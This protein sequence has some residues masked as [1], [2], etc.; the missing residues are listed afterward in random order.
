MIVNR[1]K[2]RRLLDALYTPLDYFSGGIDSKD[3]SIG[4]VGIMAVREQQVKVATA[5]RAFFVARR[6]IGFGS[7]VRM[8]VDHVAVVRV[9]VV[10]DAHDIGLADNREIVRLLSGVGG[11]IVFDDRPILATERATGLVGIACDDMGLHLVVDRCGD[12]HNKTCFSYHNTFASN[13]P[14]SS[15]R[16]RVHRSSLRYFQPPSARMATILP[17]SMLSAIRRAACRD[18][19]QEGPAKIPSWSLS[20]RV[21]RIESIAETRILPSSSVL[22]NMGGTKPSCRLRR[23]CTAS[24]CI[25]SA[26][27]TLIAGLCSFR[28]RAD[29]V[30]VPP[31]PSPATKTSRSGR[32][33]MISGAVP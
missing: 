15:R 29:P 11:R 7:G 12:T 5:L 18:A 23:P 22:S 16:L 33:R 32:S 28:R 21:R 2:I 20:W 3:A 17:C 24:P 1:F 19:P 10:I 31:V 9:D 8:I 25:G 30:S 4:R 6:G 27:T 14:S 26:A 13:S